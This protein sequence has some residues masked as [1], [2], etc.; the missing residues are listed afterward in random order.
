MSGTALSDGRLQ[1]SVNQGYSN[2]SYYTGSANLNYTSEYGDAGLGY[3]YNRS[4]KMLDYR[5]TGGF[6]AH[7]DGITLSQPLGDTNVLIKAPGAQSVK[8]QNTTGI[9]TDLRGYAVVPY[10]TSYRNNRIALDTRTLDDHT[11]LDDSVVNVV[12]TKGALALASFNARVGYR[13]IF[14]LVTKDK[15]SVPFASTALEKESSA[16]GIVDDNSHV[17]LTGIGEKGTIVVSWGPGEQD[18]CT[19]SYTFT[20]AQ[21]KQPVVQTDAVCLQ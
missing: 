9:K 1:Y 19:A 14:N 11:D 20:D 2:K 12:P 16:T 4:Y 3:S 17:Y 15:K 13:A 7:H 21:L 6:V 18:K 8:V 10:S 5:L